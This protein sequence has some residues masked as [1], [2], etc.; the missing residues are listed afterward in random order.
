MTKKDEEAKKSA[1][2]N[3]SFQSLFSTPLFGSS[4]LFGASSLLAP[5]PPTT[6]ASDQKSFETRMKDTLGGSSTYQTTT[7]LPPATSSIPSF[8][9]SLFGTSSL[10]SP[11]FLSTTATTVT[12]P[13]KTEE[14]KKKEFDDRMKSLGL[15]GSKPADSKT[16][17]VATSALGSFSNILNLSVVPE[18]KEKTEA[19]KKKNLMTGWLPS[20]E[21][22]PE[23]LFQR[24]K[25]QL[26]K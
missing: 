5:T 2:S 6:S 1:D 22:N 17:D 3:S 11:G 14:E 19:E 16:P 21:K 7:A 26:K 8:S 25:H 24:S 15:F 18:K 9:S 13:T 20:L 4:G 10:F 23:L 12:P